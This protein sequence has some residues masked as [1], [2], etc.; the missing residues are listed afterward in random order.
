MY[1][2]IFFHI[3][4]YMDIKL[5]YLLKKFRKIKNIKKYLK[6]IKSKKQT[7]INFIYIIN[8]KG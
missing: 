5:F 6:K 1:K 8:K 3:K 4:V 2:K 7:I